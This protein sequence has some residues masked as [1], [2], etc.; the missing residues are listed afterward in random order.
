MELII[1]DGYIK[2]LVIY[3]KIIE[4]NVPIADYTFDY[5]FTVNRKARTIDT[6]SINV[7][8]YTGTDEAT[9]YDKDGT[10]L[11]VVE[12][13]PA[14]F[15]NSAFDFSNGGVHLSKS[16]TFATTVNSL[17]NESGYAKGSSNTSII[18]VTATG[19]LNKN[20]TITGVVVMELPVIKGDIIY[21][22]ASNYSNLR[23]DTDNKHVQ[24]S[25]NRWEISRSG[26][27]KISSTGNAK[28]DYIGIGIQGA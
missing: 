25:S 13:D 18:D 8:V 16:R 27:F 2:G 10:V 21:L 11:E 23:Y 6:S 28:I 7:F 19:T 17:S 22:N 20:G 5:C 3:N 15:D 24:S 9:V 14:Y 26:I 12:T 1:E 4:M